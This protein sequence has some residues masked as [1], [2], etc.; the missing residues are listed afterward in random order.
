MPSSKRKRRSKLYERKQTT[1]AVAPERIKWPGPRPE[2][3]P[4][5]DMTPEEVAQAMFKV[6]GPLP[7]MK[8]VP[9]Y[10]C[11]V[12]ERRVR[13]P[14]ILYRDGCCEQCHEGHRNG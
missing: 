6:K 5:I 1:P 9:A 12:C 8:V 3:P 7:P 4:R 2:P 13:Y 14:E 10:Y 11:A